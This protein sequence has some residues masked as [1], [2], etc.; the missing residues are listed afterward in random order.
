MDCP[1]CGKALATEQGTRQHHTKVHGN[2]LPNRTCEDC[3]VEFYD[4][5]SRRTY[6]EKCY[7]EAGDK[8]GNYSGAKETTECDRCGDRF[9]YYPSDKDGIY[10]SKCV[11]NADGLFPNDGSPETKV[12]VACEHC[13]STLKRHPSRIESASYGVFCDLDCYGTWLSN[14]VVGEDHHQWRG[15]TVPYGPTWWAVRRTAL[16]RD[17]YECQKCGAGVAELGRNPDVHHIEPV[18]EFENP[19]AAHQLDNVICL[20]RPC[21]RCIEDGDMVLPACTP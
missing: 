18:R 2:P 17:N 4:P 10:C 20:C 14:N 9:E 5:K 1:T 16:E 13:G 6:C 7:S 3:G 21:H 12:E 15:G 19:E 11:A 8:N